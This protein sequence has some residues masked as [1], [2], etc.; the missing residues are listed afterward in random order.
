M[1]F[2]LTHMP[3]KGTVFRHCGCCPSGQMG[4]RSLHRGWEHNSVSCLCV[5]KLHYRAHRTAHLR[6]QI[7]QVC[8][9]LNSFIRV[10]PRLHSA[11]SKA[12]GYYL[13]TTSVNLVCQDLCGSCFQA[14]H[15]LCQWWSPADFLVPSV[16][17]FLTG[18]TRALST[19]SCAGL[20]GA[21]VYM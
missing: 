14:P 13:G 15:S 16:F 18:G 5:V 3:L 21:I 6:V 12:I 17:S 20:G 7:R 19:W 9:P 2:P 1:L 10:C 11:T 4:L 8:T